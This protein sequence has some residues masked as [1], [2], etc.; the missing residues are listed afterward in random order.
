M[1][2][3][4]WLSGLRLS[5]LKLIRFHSCLDRSCV[6][7]KLGSLLDI[8]MRLLRAKKALNSMIR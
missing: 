7:V 5:F 3:L 8:I 6:A 4:V 2:T 1:P